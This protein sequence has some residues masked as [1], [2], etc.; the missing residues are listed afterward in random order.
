MK[1]YLATWLLEESQG[2]TL[3]KLSQKRRLLSYFHT[4]KKIKKFIQYIK[5][6]I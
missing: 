3:T 1:I 6:G 2:Q 5:T 4:M